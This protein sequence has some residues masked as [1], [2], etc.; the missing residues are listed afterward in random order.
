[1]HYGLNVIALA[2]A[3]MMLFS[4][5][6]ASSAET[7]HRL[8]GGNS[9]SRFANMEITDDVCWFD[10]LWHHKLGLQAVPVG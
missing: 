7:F 9:R 3:V 6:A 1:M 4:G 10:S 8:K 2:G 5:L